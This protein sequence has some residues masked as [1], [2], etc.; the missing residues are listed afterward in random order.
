MEDGTILSFGSSF[1][2]AKEDVEAS[3]LSQQSGDLITPLDAFQSVATLLDLDIQNVSQARA[4]PSDG[5]SGEFAIRGV[6][7]TVSNPKAKLVYLQK[8]GSVILTW[9]VETNL[10]SGW[11]LTYVDASTGKEI[12][13]AVDH[14]HTSTYEA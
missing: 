10:D 9:R 1:Y 7:G 8:N 4:E 11:L 6:E 3:P 5:S 13:G 14:T 12:A 2:T